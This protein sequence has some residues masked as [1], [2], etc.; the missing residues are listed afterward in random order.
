MHSA[1]LIILQ[2]F[3]FYR[4]QGGGGGANAKPPQRF[5]V[6]WHTTINLILIDQLELIDGRTYLRGTACF[7]KTPPKELVKGPFHLSNWLD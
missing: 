3:F 1:F 5:A 7:A 2:E 4:T 6:Q